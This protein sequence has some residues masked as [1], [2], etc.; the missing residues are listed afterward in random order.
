MTYPTSCRN[1]GTTFFLTFS[2][3][4]KPS[5]GKKQYS[6]QRIMAIPSASSSAI[7]HETFLP[8]SSTH[9]A[10]KTPSVMEMF[11]LVCLPPSAS[12]FKAS[13]SSKI[14]VQLSLNPRTN[15]TIMVLSIIKAE[16]LCIMCRNLP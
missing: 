15:C 12:F 10:Q 3:S 1:G 2:L 4:L 7:S 5:F 14:C 9:S 8:A 13:F 16:G 6:F 11:I